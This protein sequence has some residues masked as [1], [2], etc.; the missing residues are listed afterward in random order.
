MRADKYLTE[1]DLMQ[2]GIRPKIDITRIARQKHAARLQHINKAF[3][4]SCLIE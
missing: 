2:R 3:L 1:S 4:S